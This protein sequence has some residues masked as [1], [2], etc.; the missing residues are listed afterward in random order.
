MATSVAPGCS[1]VLRRITRFG[2]VGWGFE[3]KH[4]PHHIGDFDKATRH[5]TRIER[6]VYRDLIDLYYDTEQPLTLD[7]AALCRRIIARSNEES[8]AVEQVLNEFFTETPTGWYHDR[9][10]EEIAAYHANTS[11]KALAGKASA[12]AK[13]LKK[14]QAMNG[15]STAVE[16]PLPAVEA[17]GQRNSTNQSTINQSTNQP[18]SVTDVTGGAAAKP[19]DA[20]TKDEL[21]TAGKSLLSAVMPKA[22]CGSFVGK[23][24]KDYGDAVVVEA[25]RAAVVT[26]PA[27]PIEYL[28]ATCQRAAGQRQPVNKQEALEQRNRQVAAV[29]A[30]EGA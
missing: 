23:L 30:A 25:V 11:Q 24:V 18:S 19:I 22:Q 28:K 3:L 6:S 10:E 20:M 15:S 13:R 21:W 26:R 16:Q 9:C 5:L 8:T 7:K 14:L 29:W 17:D 12:E 1:R 2:L 27:D 4:Y